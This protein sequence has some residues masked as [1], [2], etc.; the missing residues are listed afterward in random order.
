MMFTDAL[1]IHEETE[2]HAVLGKHGKALFANRSRT[3][4]LNNGTAT[5]RRDGSGTGI[6]LR[7][8]GDVMQFVTR[9]LTLRFE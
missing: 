8:S 5:V 9:C 2:P 4:S 3:D 7:S 1:I 6:A